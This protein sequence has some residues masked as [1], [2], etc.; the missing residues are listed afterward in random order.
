MNYALRQQQADRPK[1]L[2]PKKAQCL[3]AL[4][5]GPVT[6]VWD[7]V[8]ISPTTGQT[9]NTHVVSW[10]VSKGWAQFNKHRTEATITR[11]GKQLEMTME[12]A[13]YE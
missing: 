11:A 10:L 1:P 2:T 6:G 4:T 8:W 9:W 3:S 5:R 13:D 7:T 12:V